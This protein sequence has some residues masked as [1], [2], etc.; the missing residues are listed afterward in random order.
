MLFTAIFMLPT[1]RRIDY[2]DTI[3]PTVKAE[4]G[5]YNAITDLKSKYPE[6]YRIASCESGLRQYDAFGGVLQGKVDSADTGFLQI[7][8]DAHLKEIQSMGLNV[9]KL[10][11]NIRF[12]IWLYQK[13]GTIPW[14]ASK[15]CWSSS[16]A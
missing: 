3:I 10:D 8:L 6:L 11:D 7:N 9:A 12:G 4:D 2:G 5:T 15:K 14:T 16:Q 13:E 1:A